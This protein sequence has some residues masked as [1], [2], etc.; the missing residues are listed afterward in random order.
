[1]APVS[2]WRSGGWGRGRSAGETASA[3]R[4]PA[5]RRRVSACGAGLT[6][7]A[8]G[9]RG[10]GGGG[11]DVVEADTTGI[12][13]RVVVQ[14][15]QV[16]AAVVG[17]HDDRGVEGVGVEVLA[18]ALDGVR[19][20]RS[21][22]VDRALGVGTH[23]DDLACRG[24]LQEP[25]GAGDG[26]ARADPCEEMRDPSVG[27]AP[28][29]GPRGLVMRAGTV[30]V[31]E[32]VR[33]VR[34]RDLS[35]E[36]VGHRVVRVEMLGRHVRRH[37]DDL[38]TVGAQHRGL[39]AGEL[40]GH[41]E[42]HPIPPLQGD[43]SE[44]DTRVAARRLDDRTPGAEGTGCLGGIDDPRGDAVFRRAAGVQVLDLGQDGR[45]GAVRDVVEADERGASDEVGDVRGVAHGS[46]LGWGRERRERMPAETGRGGRASCGGAVGVVEESRN[47][48]AT[49]ATGQRHAPT[50]T[51]RLVAAH[52]IVTFRHA[53][54]CEHTVRAMTRRSS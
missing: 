19:V 28:D 23:D 52:R 47:G 36:P 29:L 18:D 35:C 30:R 13:P 50:V 38:G 39:L 3:R 31:R 37:L 17:Q 21:T 20:D 14:P 1:M 12:Q 25:S 10:G 43:Q 46:V 54:S 8:G 34:A 44:T 5:S 11:G 45:V 16:A 51:R 32:L 53:A 22:G 48:S 26:A 4:D 40:V 9:G 27:V 33:L 42:D 41:D 6:G 24:I 7:Y 15:R 2:G 49:T